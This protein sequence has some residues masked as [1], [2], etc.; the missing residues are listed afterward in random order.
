MENIINGSDLVIKWGASG[1]EEVVVC[2]TSCTATITAEMKAVKCKGSGKW[3]SNTPGDKSF[4]LSVDALY[5]E[6]ATG[7]GKVFADIF[8]S[9]AGDIEVSVVFGLD[10]PTTGDSLYTGNA[11]FSTTSLTAAAGEDATFSATLV[12]NGELVRTTTA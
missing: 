10:S 1:S 9:I 5:I 2:S 4:E 12:G 8:D 6:S 7:T 11:Y 3:K